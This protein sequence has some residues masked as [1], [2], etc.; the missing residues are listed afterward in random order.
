MG[1]YGFQALFK[2][3]GKPVA[4]LFFAPSSNK[5]HKL[6]SQ[7]VKNPNLISI[8]KIEKMQSGKMPIINMEDLA[9]I[10]PYQGF[11]N[12]SKKH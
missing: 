4:K 8:S 9:A 10:H 11:K 1:K 5:A 6:R 7:V 12:A 2:E 3:M